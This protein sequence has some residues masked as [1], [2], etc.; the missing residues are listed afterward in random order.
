MN[1]HDE[2]CACIRHMAS[3]RTILCIGGI[4][5]GEADS[6]QGGAES[7]CGVKVRTLRGKRTPQS[8]SLGPLLTRSLQLIPT[9]VPVSVLVQGRV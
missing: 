6:S 4:A 5:E 8:G 1:E 3:L 2:F 9:P 7:R